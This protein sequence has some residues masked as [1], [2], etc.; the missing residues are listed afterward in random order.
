MDAAVRAA[1]VDD[2][3]GAPAEGRLE[4]V[5]HPLVAEGDDDGAVRVRDA[6]RARVVVL[7]VDSGGAVVAVCAV[8][9]V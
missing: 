6:A 7:V 5:V 1:G 8:L 2:A 4:L 9:L 3:D